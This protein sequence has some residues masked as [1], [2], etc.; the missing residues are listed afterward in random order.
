VL[1]FD[2]DQRIIEFEGRL[3]IVYNNHI[4]RDGE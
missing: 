4:I 3:K 2:S 1:F